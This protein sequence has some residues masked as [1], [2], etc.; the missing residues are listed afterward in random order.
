VFYNL[1]ARRSV[2]LSLPAEIYDD[3]IGW[4]RAS[5]SSGRTD[6]LP[7]LSFS[8]AD[9]PSVPLYIHFADLV[10]NASD[11]TSPGGLPVSTAAGGRDVVCVL[12]GAAILD[13]GGNYNL[14]PISLGSMVLKSLVFAA[15]YETRSVGFANKVDLLAAERSVAVGGSAPYCASVVVCRGAQRYDPQRNQCHSPACENY[16]FASLD[17]HTQRCTYHVSSYGLGLVLILVFI[18]MEI[19]SFS[20]LKK[21]ELELN[22]SN[23]SA[24]R[25]AFGVSST[26]NKYLLPAVTV[27]TRFLDVFIVNCLG[28]SGPRPDNS[29]TAVA[30][31][32]LAE[33]ATRASSAAN[34][35]NSAAADRLTTDPDTADMA[36][37]TAPLRV[38]RTVPT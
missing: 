10:V 21:V 17:A 13:G 3:L 6:D 38:Q 34:R 20:L 5:S 36:D 33:S 1:H 29:V 19:G 26:T 28:W 27:I 22:E 9:G 31:R 25:D 4:W 11:I 37:S 14:P 23:R 16:Y 8:L 24:S 18:A 15:N 12:R 35:G 7:Y 30:R 2:C 32:R